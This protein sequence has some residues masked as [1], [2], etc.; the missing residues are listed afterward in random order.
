MVF[1]IPAVAAPWKGAQGRKRLRAEGLKVER[2]SGMEYLYS[3][4]V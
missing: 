2:D 3:T 4:S 1:D